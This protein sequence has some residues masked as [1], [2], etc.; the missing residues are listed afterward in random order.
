MY[1]SAITAESFVELVASTVNIGC[2]L[3][4]DFYLDVLSRLEQLLY[5]EYIREERLLF[6]DAIDGE[7]DLSQAQVPMGERDPRADDVFAVYFGDRPLRR[8]RL[9]EAYLLDPELGQE[10]FYKSDDAKISLCLSEEAEVDDVAVFYYAAPR[11]KTG[12]GRCDNVALPF[13]FLP[14]AEAKLRG[15]AYKLADDDAAAAKWLAEYNSLVA[16]FAAWAKGRVA[17]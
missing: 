5:S 7:I 12:D 14:L 13:E 1:D 6:A 11:L 15:E 17:V 16:S 8:I 9:S 3:P 4:D 2:T 10:S